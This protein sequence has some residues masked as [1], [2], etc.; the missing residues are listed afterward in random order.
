ML[1][2]VFQAIR[3]QKHIHLHIIKIKQTLLR[4]NVQKSILKTIIEDIRCINFF[5]T[6]IWIYPIS[7]VGV[8]RPNQMTATCLM[9]PTVGSWFLPSCSMC[10]VVSVW[11]DRIIPK[12]K[13]SYERCLGGGEQVMT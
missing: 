13:P 5:P 12:Q 11:L 4:E 10:P 3:L 6:S 8:D 1:K 2:V 9:W 7:L